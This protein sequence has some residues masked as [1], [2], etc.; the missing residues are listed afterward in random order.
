MEKTV[1][2]L[3]KDFGKSKKLCTLILLF[4]LNCLFIVL[5][6]YKNDF[7]HICLAVRALLALSKVRKYEH[8]LKEMIECVSVNNVDTTD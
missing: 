2:I 1:L 8:E 7:E 4:I 3:N 5:Q 6:D